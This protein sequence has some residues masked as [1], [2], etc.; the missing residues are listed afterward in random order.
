[1]SELNRPKAKSVP[2]IMDMGMVMERIKGRMLR[3]KITASP[4]GTF[5]LRTRSKRRK[6][7]LVMNRQVR[8]ATHNRKAGVSSLRI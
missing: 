3:Y 6:I 5:L 2:T 8:R 7:L 4:D 1:M